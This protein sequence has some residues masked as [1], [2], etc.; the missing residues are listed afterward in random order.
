MGWFNHQLG[1]DGSVISWGNPSCGGDTFDVQDQLYDVNFIK[2]T[3]V[4]FAAIRADGT[5][6]WTFVFNKNCFS[7]KG[8]AD[9]W[10]LFFWFGGGEDFSLF[11]F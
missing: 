10:R 9:I 11:I 6:T 7:R 1:T 4:A 3:K 5:V 8:G 2:G